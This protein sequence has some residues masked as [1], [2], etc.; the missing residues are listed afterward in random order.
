MSDRPCI[1]LILPAYNEVQRV[2]GTIAEAKSS[3]ERRNYTYELIVS[4]D[5][6]DG[7]RELVAKMAKT[8]PTVKVTGSVER[9]GRGYGICQGV[10]LAQGEVIGFADADNKTPIEEFGKFE[11]WLRDGY[12]VVIGS[13]ALRGSGH[14]GG[15]S[16]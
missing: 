8:D 13:R 7:T 9:R 15:P 12:E 1:S 10:A 11:T 2:A 14:P 3:F 16:R 5:G 4:A 6:D